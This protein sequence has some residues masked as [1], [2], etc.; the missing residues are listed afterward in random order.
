M[1]FAK[2]RER[3]RAKRNAKSAKGL[4]GL[5]VRILCDL[6]VEEEEVGGCLNESRSADGIPSLID[7]GEKQ[8]DNSKTKE[9]MSFRDAPLFDILLL[10]PTG[11][12]GVVAKMAMSYKKLWKQLIDR[13][14]TRGDLHRVS[15]VA[16]STFT[17]MSNGECVATNVIERICKALNC[18]V[19]DI[20]E[21]VPGKET[22]AEK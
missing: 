10:N 15:G 12:S 7:S 2:E 5:C 4:C 20:M 14:M 17:K 9:A 21:V 11:L 13:D 22:G 18:D 3:E 1:A 8:T 6:C 19:G 16:L